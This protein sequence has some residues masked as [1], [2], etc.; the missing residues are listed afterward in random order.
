MT[1]KSNH[2]DV[3]Y[4]IESDY[5]WGGIKQLVP[6]QTFKSENKLKQFVFHPVAWHYI[7][8]QTDIAKRSSYCTVLI[9]S[10]VPL[11][12]VQLN[13]LGLCKRARGSILRCVY[14]LFQTENLPE[15]V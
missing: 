15:S 10:A 6:K 3:H 14:F 12:V 1:F 8:L 11:V 5:L 7:G 2:V 13:C 4:C 9:L